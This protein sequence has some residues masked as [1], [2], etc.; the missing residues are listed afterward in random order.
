MAFLLTV[1]LPVSA[2]DAMTLLSPAF[3]PSSLWVRPWRILSF[4]IASPLSPAPRRGPCGGPVRAY[5]APLTLVSAAMHRSSQSRVL[6][7]CCLRTLSSSVFS[8]MSTTMVFLSVPA[9]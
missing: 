8:S 9:L 3:A 7:T 1:L 5:P 2:R 6:W 4:L